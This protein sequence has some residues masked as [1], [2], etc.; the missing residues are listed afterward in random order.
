KTY[1]RLLKKELEGIGEFALLSSIAT[2][3]LVSSLFLS[4]T[5]FV[6]TQN[7]VIF[8]TALGFLMNMSLHKD[9]PVTDSFE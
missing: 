1:K 5:V 3:C 2:A 4:D 8:W 7:S 9:T 6:N